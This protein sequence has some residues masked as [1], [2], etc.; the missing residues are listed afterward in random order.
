GPRLP[1]DAKQRGHDHQQHPAHRRDHAGRANPQHYGARLSQR[2]CC[3]PPFPCRREHSGHAHRAAGG[4]HRLDRGDQVW[5]LLACC[6][7]SPSGSSA[8]KNTR[9]AKD[10][11]SRTRTGPSRSLSR[12]AR[13]FPTHRVI[14]TP[15]LD[16]YFL[17]PDSSAISQEFFVGSD[18]GSGVGWRPWYKPRGCTFI[19]FTIVGAGGGGGA[20][21]VGAASA[22]G[23][24]GGGG[25][26]GWGQW[27]I[28]AFYLP[29]VLYIQVGTG[30]AGGKTSGQSGSGGKA[31]YV[32]LAP[33]TSV[34]P[35]ASAAGGSGGTGGAASGAAAVG[36][37]A[38]VSTVWSGVG[39]AAVT[40]SSAGTAGGDATSGAGS[41]A[42]N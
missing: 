16:T 26:G 5:K 24:G 8:L 14:R 13:P 25:G 21:F 9:A 36:A 18:A 17:P 3:Q 7:R 35:I 30:G 39:I 37:V 15:M 33:S 41:G 29:D 12:T 42:L 32:A 10:S 19:F 22:A 23:G 4:E 6:C 31:T 40:A 11:R 38:G 2:G 1:F 20:G 28:P 34:G 27:F